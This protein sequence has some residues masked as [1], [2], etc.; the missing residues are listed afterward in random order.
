GYALGEKKDWDKSRQAYER[1]VASFGN[2]PWV[3]EARYGMAWARQQSAKNDAQYDE[4]ITLY[5]QVTNAL[6]TELAAR[7]Q[8]NVGLCRMAQKK[9][10]EAGTAFLGVPYTYDYP[11]LS[12]LALI[13]A[14][15]SFSES[16]QTNQ[17]V[18]LLR[19]VVKDYAGTEHAE[20]AKKR[21]IDLGE[22]G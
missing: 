4:A 10:P 14:A 15:R 19:R 16:K 9:Y 5:T 21:L 22:D 12:A 8:V 6:S 1:I 7:A 2:G 11:E 20:A 17:A 18:K 3:H 13:E